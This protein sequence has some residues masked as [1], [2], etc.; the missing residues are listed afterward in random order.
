[1][2]DSLFTIL[3]DRST[4][5]AEFRKAAHGL[6]S[7][8]TDE[9]AK[10]IEKNIAN[11]KRNVILIS[12]LRSGIT[13]LPFFIKK[14]PEAKVGFMGLRRDEKTAIAHEYYRNLPKI[15]KSD[16][17]II[18]DPMIAT[19]GSAIDTLEVLEKE[20]IEEGQTFFT[21]LIAAPEGLEKIKSRYPNVK[22]ILGVKDK[23][24][25]KDKFII[26][27][28]GDFGDRYFGTERG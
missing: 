7:I 11:Q 22:I 4:K 20:G 6:L 13:F 9:T 5:I 17:V 3:R 25:D 23:G 26:P 10:K 14:F 21:A 27:G 28:I 8:L 24:L 12:I 16:I 19:G 1:M 15:K 18:L 2:K